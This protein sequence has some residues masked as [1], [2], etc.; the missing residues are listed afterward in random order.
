MAKDKET[1]KKEIQKAIEKEKKE[2]VKDKKGGFHAWWLIGLILPPVGLV[3]YILLF[4]KRKEDSKSV[5]TGALISS[6]FWLILALSFVGGNNNKTNEITEN[7]TNL[8]KEVD[9][10]LAST[11]IQS[12]YNDLSSGKA[13]VT[14]I[15][16]STCPHCQNL[17]PVI[18][19]SAKKNNYKLYFFEADTLEED[20]YLILANSIELDGYE[21]YVP[22]IFVVKDKEFKGSHTGEME[23][24]DLN[25][26]LEQTEVL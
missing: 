4:K 2:L 25:D 21:G 1:I 19:A 6:I 3:L 14:V 11:E 12:W 23:D 13:V 18:T 24:D 7:G 15:A 10:S 20:D 17:K 8:L 16:S 5:G 22:Y 26:F 9:V